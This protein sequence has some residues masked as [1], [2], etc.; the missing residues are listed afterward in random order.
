MKA[1]SS[2]VEKLFP[3]MKK[4]KDESI[5]E[6]VVE[7][8]LR[9]LQDGVYEKIEECPFWAPWRQKVEWSLVDH[10]NQVTAC[11][12]AIGD[13]VK[14]VQGIDVKMDHLIA[15]ALLHDLDKLVGFTVDGEP[16][17][18]TSKTP[19]G[20][21][22]A[23]V[24]MDVDLPLD[25]VHMILSHTAVSVQGPKTIEALIL[26]YADYCI[27]DTRCLTDG[28]KNLWVNVIPRYAQIADFKTE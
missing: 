3:A 20:F 2:Y 15:G 10:V 26:H 28:V 22:S 24:A 4:I 18:I 9:G 17:E 5:R 13:V 16:T 7:A 6:K 12:M 14:E 8:F 1:D 11:A 23:H 25:V 21:Y 27:A 19:H